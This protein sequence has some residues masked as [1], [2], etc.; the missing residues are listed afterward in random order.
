MVL[1]AKYLIQY[2]TQF[3]VHKTITKNIILYDVVHDKTIYQVITNV[4]P[5]SHPGI[6]YC[7]NFDV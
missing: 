6:T 3:K 1:N 7:I 5:I 4:L 2:L